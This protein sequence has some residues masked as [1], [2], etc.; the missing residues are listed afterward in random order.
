M[1]VKRNVTYLSTIFIN[2]RFVGSKCWSVNL[3]VH[4]SYTGE[5]LHQEKNV[6][7]YLQFTQKQRQKVKAY[8]IL[9]F[10]RFSGGPETLP[11]KK[12]FRAPRD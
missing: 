7:K 1:C 9:R 12:F 11:P 6:L 4:C 8:N 3:K 5:L 10:T 2:P